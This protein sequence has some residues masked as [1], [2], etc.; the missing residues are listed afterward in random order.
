VR[1]RLLGQVGDAHAEG[2][3]GLELS[4]QVRKDKLA[5]A[6]AFTETRRGWH[7]GALGIPYRVTGRSEVERRGWV[8]TMH[9]AGTAIR[10]GS[11]PG[12]GPSPEV[13]TSMRMR[14]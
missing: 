9:A 13:K 8:V 5:V 6:S 4:H 1:A 14:S 11:G 3:V 12:S 10:R 7:R 2:A